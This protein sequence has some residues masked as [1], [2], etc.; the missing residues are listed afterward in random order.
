MHARHVLHHKVMALVLNIPS[1]LMQ[2]SVAAVIF[3]A[4]TEAVEGIELILLCLL[5]LK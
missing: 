1:F 3:V 2:I 4:S 5:R